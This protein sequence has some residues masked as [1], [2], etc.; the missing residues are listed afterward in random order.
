MRCA[1]KRGQQRRASRFA[2]FL[3]ELDSSGSDQTRPMGSNS[4]R[5]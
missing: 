4:V 3:N 5:F 1:E 2:I